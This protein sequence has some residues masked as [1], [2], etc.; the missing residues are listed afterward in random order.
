MSWILAFIGGKWKEYAMIAAISFVLMG[1]V[2]IKGRLDERSS[3]KN[4]QAD[5]VIATPGKIITG[6]QAINKAIKNA[7]D[8]CSNTALPSF[9]AHELR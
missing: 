2:Y 4:A 6:T 9:I 1:G 3:I 7:K 8:Q 5:R